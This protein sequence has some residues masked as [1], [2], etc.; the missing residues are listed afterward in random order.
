M[1]PESIT[2]RLVAG[3]GLRPVEIAPI[4][5]GTATI[6]FRVVDGDGRAWFVKV[7]RDPTRLDRDRAAIELSLF[8]GAGGVPVP[9]LLR[10]RD[11]GLISEG[12]PPLSVWEYVE[13]AETA[14]G[15]LTG[16]RWVS[17][18]TLLGRLHRRL[19][20]HP[21]LA[22]APRPATGLVDLARSRERH[23]R[24]IAGH[25]DRSDSFAAWARA[26]ARV[27]L[28]LLDRVADLLAGLPPLTVQVAHG[29]LAAPNLLLRGDAVA[30]LVDF[31]PPGPYHLAWEIARIGCDPRTVLRDDHWPAGLV[32][33][34]L[35]YR[36]EHPDARVEDLISSVA[37]GCCYTLAS[38]YPLAAAVQGPVE[39]SLQAYG[40]ARHEAALIMLDR[41]DETETL[42]RDAL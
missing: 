14:E 13:Q 31:Q 5:T 28:P 2:G 24:L 42:L 19:A 6:N 25:G 8:A 38:T 3:H 29:D 9:R 30:A 7:Y 12:T 11:G 36:A 35:A 20:E 10:T 39:E 27:R 21:S 34:A 22:P 41:L 26:A 18:G 17:V 15:G 23:R 16:R 40:R 1:Q 33:L 32:E 37:A 4:P